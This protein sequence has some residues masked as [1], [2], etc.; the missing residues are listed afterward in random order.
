MWFNHE[1]G[2]GF[3]RMDDGRNV[4]ISHREFEGL[5]YLSLTTEI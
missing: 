5:V 1:K 2:Y 3:A 4:Y